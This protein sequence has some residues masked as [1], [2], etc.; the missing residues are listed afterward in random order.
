MNTKAQLLLV[1]TLGLALSGFSQND[2]QFKTQR[3]HL[4]A[5]VNAEFS[6][7]MKIIATASAYR[8][9]LFILYDV[10]TGRELLSLKITTGYVNSIKFSPDGKWVIITED[11]GS[12]KIIDVKSGDIIR[13]HKAEWTDYYAEFSDDNKLYLVEN[14]DYIFIH[15]KTTGKLIAKFYNDDMYPKSAHFSSDGKSIIVGYEAYYG[16]V[17]VFDIEKQEMIFELKGADSSLSGAFFDETGEFFY[18]HGNFLK[19]WKIKKLKVVDKKP[20]D[21]YHIISPDHL[22]YASPTNWDETN[23]YDIETNRFIQDI[24]ETEDVYFYSKVKKEG[25]ARTYY[26]VSIP[27]NFVVMY[28]DMILNY[29]DLWEFTV[30]EPRFQLKKIKRFEGAVENVNVVKTGNRN[31]LLV[32]GD[33]YVN[34]WDLNEMRNTHRYNDHIQ[35]TVAIDIDSLAEN[36][37]ASTGYCFVKTWN[38][39][40]PSPVKSYEWD[41]L[42]AISQILFSKDLKYIL[43]GRY[44]GFPLIWNIDG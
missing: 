25:N 7:D 20:I 16:T 4:S 3:G 38:I 11:N 29:V 13:E 10:E 23:L 30:D 8:D 22:M 34:L 21:P 2:L 18:T 41:K 32:G 27:R 6:P 9:G 39:N 35:P 31:R 28:T 17:K 12:T 44:D 26:F 36:F 5:V 19:K 40:Q 43:A 37:I 15:E 1:F 14:F 33:F 42:K 24:P